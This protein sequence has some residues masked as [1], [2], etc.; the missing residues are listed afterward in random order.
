MLIGKGEKKTMCNSFQ[1]EAESK[2]CREGYYQGI[3]DAISGLFEKPAKE[4]RKEIED[5]VRDTLKPWRDNGGQ[6]P[7]FPRL[8]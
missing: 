7:G 3:V 8:D 5:W 1:T 6:K 4:N 2:A